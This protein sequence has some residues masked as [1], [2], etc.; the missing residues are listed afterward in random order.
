LGYNGE[1][2]ANATKAIALR[3]TTETG[4]AENTET[5]N[6]QCTNMDKYSCPTFIGTYLAQA[7]EE[8][9]SSDEKDKMVV[10]GHLAD[11]PNTWVWCRL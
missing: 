9:A 10:L 7:P 4:P 2:Y 3:N 6:S 1:K 5:G 11:C 8:V